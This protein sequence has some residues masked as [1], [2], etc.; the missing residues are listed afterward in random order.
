MKERKE[1]KDNAT[2]GK[3]PSVVLGSDYPGKHV[4]IQ[5]FVNC[6]SFRLF[7]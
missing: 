1:Y 7:D 5:Q 3:S 6:V 4:F 2:M